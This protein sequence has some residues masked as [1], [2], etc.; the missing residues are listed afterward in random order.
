MKEPIDNHNR[1]FWII[2]QA[3]LCFQI[4][5]GTF[6]IFSLAYEIIKNWR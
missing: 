4:L 2:L 5:G 6:L 1:K 3:L